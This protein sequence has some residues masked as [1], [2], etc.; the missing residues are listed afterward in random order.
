MITKDEIRTTLG[1]IRFYY[2]NIRSFQ[3]ASKYVGENR[4]VETAENYNRAIEN[5]PP[6]LYELY[7]HLYI[8]NGMMASVAAELNYSIGYINKLNNGLVKYF[9]N[10][11]DK[12]EEGE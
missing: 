7:I 5:A 9:Y 2:A 10:Y 6:K 1:D 4:I 3:N 12:N 8:N 11:F